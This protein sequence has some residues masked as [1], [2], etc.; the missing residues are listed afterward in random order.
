M[1]SPTLALAA[2]LSLVAAPDIQPGTQL[3][4]TGTMA[5]VKDDGD[6]AVK[7]FT[8]TLLALPGEGDAA[9]FAWT[10]DEEGRGGWSWCRTARR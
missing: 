9:R 4:Y 5:G 7:K 10:L 1:F 6:P 3:T 2:A 8:L